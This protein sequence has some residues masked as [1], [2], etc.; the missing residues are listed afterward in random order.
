MQ[1]AARVGVHAVTRT[2]TRGYNVLAIRHRGFRLDHAHLWLEQQDAAVACRGEQPPAARQELQVPDLLSRRGRSAAASRGSQS[3]PAA[4]DHPILKAGAIVERRLCGF[5][6]AESMP[7]AI[8]QDLQIQPPATAD[9]L[10][11]AGVIRLPL[12]ISTPPQLPPHIND[13]AD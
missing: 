1:A 7:L 3:L 12:C 5:T 10:A 8:W 4:P 13:S 6:R 11:P 9:P 2:I